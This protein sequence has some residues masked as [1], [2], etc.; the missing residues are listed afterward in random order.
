MKP[1]AAAGPG[2]IV[3]GCHRGLENSEQFVEM[4]GQGINDDLGRTGNCAEGLG[5][6]LVEA[7]FPGQQFQHPIPNGASSSKI[8]GDI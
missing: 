4:L 5:V 8:D 7:F 1:G 6:A 2:K 3:P